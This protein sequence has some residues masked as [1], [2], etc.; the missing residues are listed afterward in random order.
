MGATNETDENGTKCASHGCPS[1][2]ALIDSVLACGVG[3][4][5]NFLNFL[6]RKRKQMAKGNRFADLAEVDNLFPFPKK[7][8]GT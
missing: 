3:A 6:M 4:R 8:K 1:H 2:C 7:M 5:S